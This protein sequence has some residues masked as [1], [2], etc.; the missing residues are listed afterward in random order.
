MYFKLLFFFFILKQEAEKAAESV[1]K[2]KTTAVI[3]SS[4]VEEVVI[5]TINEDEHSALNTTS[6]G[7]I[8]TPRIAW[9]NN[10]TSTQNMEVFNRFALLYQR[11]VWLELQQVG[12]TYCM[13]VE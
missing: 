1:D 11:R 2:A 8:M 12:P 10:S 7:V 5:S 9:A 3:E 6:S 4:G 13:N